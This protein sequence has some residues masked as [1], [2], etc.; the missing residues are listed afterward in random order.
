MLTP[1]NGNR[2]LR[3]LKNDVRPKFLDFATK[4]PTVA[5][6]A[7]I[8]GI[9]IFFWW[10]AG[11]YLGFD[12]YSSRIF[13]GADGFC[14]PSSQGLGVHCWSDYYTVVH[15]AESTNPF[16]GEQPSLYPAASLMPFMFFN[17]LTEIS[18]ILWLGLASY[19]FSMSA[20]I[21]YSVWAATKGQSF[22]RRILIF[23][24]LVLLS[25]AVLV[26]LDRGNS[27]GF[28]IPI[29]IWLFSSVKNQNSNQTITSLALLSAI[30]PHYGLVALAFILAGRI[31]IGSKA[32]GLGL[33]INILPFFVF[34]P[35]DFPNNLINWANT[36]LGY[37]EYGFITGLWPQNISF[38]Q[39]IYLVSYILDVA[40]GGLLQPVVSFIESRQGFW[41]PLVLLFIL[42][43][44]FT[45][46]KKLTLLQTS[47]LV[48]SAVSMTSAISYYYYIVVAIPFLLSLDKDSYSDAGNKFERTKTYAFRTNRINFALWVSSI[49]TLVQLPVLGIA[50]DGEQIITT[51]VFTGGVWIT[52]YVYI[53][54]VLVGSKK[55]N[56]NTPGILK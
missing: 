2:K 12:V 4:R 14:D 27:T 22:E 41:G 15:A 44:I 45:F 50:Q 7:L 17:W 36:L 5:V 49:L 46:R 9:S 23:S 30:K 21:S 19:L 39:S 37:Q 8:Q 26:V 47:I 48:I 28:L 3:I 51:A 40:S 20:L 42:G 29:L 34:W 56:S 18:G 13:L 1:G 52:C 16:F 54:A 38:S 10:V 24:V 31:K 25:P 11:S 55:K 35:R 32:L 33:T 53:L 6:L 43:L